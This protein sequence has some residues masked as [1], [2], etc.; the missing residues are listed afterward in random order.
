MKKI[1][2]DVRIPAAG[3][4]LLTWAVYVDVKLSLRYEGSE[5][6]PLPVEID[7]TLAL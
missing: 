2:S 4:E 3:I 1:K 5:K 7:S 6:G